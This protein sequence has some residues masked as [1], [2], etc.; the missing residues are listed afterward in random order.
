MTTDE[1]KLRRLFNQHLITPADKLT[2][3]RDLCGIQAQFLSNAV[4]ALA[5]RSSDLA[6]ETLADGLVKNWTLRG[7]V[8]VFAESDLPL[9]LHCG[10]NYRCNEW[11]QPSFWNQR[12]DWA[13][14]PQRQQYLS[15]LILEA[16]SDGPMPREE[17]KDHCRSA[18]MTEPEEASIFHPWGGGIRELCER[19]FLNYTVSEQK[20]FCM[21]PEF[22]PMPEEAAN[23][24]LARRY[25]TNF[26]PATIHDAQYFFR[27]TATQV[28][29]WL[30]QLPVQSTEC[31]GN[32]YYYI[33]NHRNY[34]QNIPECLFLAGF[35][36]LMLGYEKKESLFL[37]PE[38]L[39]RVFNLSGIVMPT[40]L[41]RDEIVGLWKKKGRKL[42]IELFEP[43]PSQAQALIEA[44]A[45]SLWP[46]ITKLEWK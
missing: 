43:V 31:D 42:T 33:E 21:A 4:H 45:S 27:A 46:N 41:L 20:L 2:V 22:T 6:E 1:I 24:E 32:T 5:I 39:R 37:K 35:D 23:L 44:T 10:E 17:L 19:G 13:L 8:H 18:G 12:A 14:T 15:S 40:I 3:A 9:F 28:K 36:Q 11:T 30:S 25:F 38:H 16:L 34:N 26:G 7:T 29:K